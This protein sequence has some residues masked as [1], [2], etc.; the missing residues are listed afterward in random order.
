M[1]TPICV[2]SHATFICHLWSIVFAEA[3]PNSGKI[4]VQQAMIVLSMVDWSYGHVLWFC[5]DI[6]PIGDHRS[7]TM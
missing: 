5:G 1:K 6:Y 4:G 7:L 2:Y 3:R